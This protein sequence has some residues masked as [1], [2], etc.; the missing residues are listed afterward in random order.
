MPTANELVRR[1]IV[2]CARSRTVAFGAGFVPRL[3]GRLAHLRKDCES[4]RRSNSRF[5]Q[6]PEQHNAVQREPTVG[7]GTMKPLL[8]TY[9]AFR[10]MSLRARQNTRVCP[11]WIH[12]TIYIVP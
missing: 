9:P 1:Q 2:G 6:F 7:F 10:P 11:N 4:C 3:Q 12:H 8:D 5:R